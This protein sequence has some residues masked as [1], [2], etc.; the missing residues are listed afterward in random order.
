MQRV[1]DLDLDFFVHNVAHWRDRED[2][3]LDD[4]DFPA[5]SLADTIAFL[6][7]RC[8]LTG[9]RPGIVVE[10]H[11]ELFV[12]WRD[13]ID[14]GVLRAPFHVTHIDAHADLGLGDAGFIHLLSDLLFR[15]PP[16]RR[17]PG[18]HLNDANYL[19]F[20]IGCRWLGELDYVY[21]RD[22]HRGEGPGD[23]LPCLMEDFDPRA[24]H[25]RLPALT[26]TQIE[27]L[28]FLRERPQPAR[29]EPRVPFRALPWRHYRARAPFDVI[30]LGRREVFETWRSPRC[31]RCDRSRHRRGRNR[32]PRRRAAPFSNGPRSLGRTQP[33]RS[34]QGAPPGP[35]WNGE[36]RAGAAI[37]RSCPRPSALG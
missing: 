31:V 11:G 14:A 18:E 28:S 22:D 12:R 19:A 24:A 1:L 20:A 7:D 10:H 23:I 4:E 2:G 5:W 35:R 16:E 21:N 34:D 25:I 6:T 27:D 8:D 37:S 32:L 36:L 26:R 9:V 13:A 15:T 30:C 29:W 17:E 33:A 3:R